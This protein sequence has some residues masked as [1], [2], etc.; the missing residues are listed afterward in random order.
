M[1]ARGF[2]A[3]GRWLFFGVRLV[4]LIALGASTLAITAA[5]LAPQASDILNANRSTSAEVDLDTLA[6]RSLVFDKNGAPIGQL[7]GEINRELVTLDQISQEAITTVLTVEDAA[8]Y[9]HDGINVRAI[10]RA[11]V[12]N[13]EAGGVDQGGSTITQQLIKNSVLDDAVGVEDKIPE[14]A[15]AMRLEG[16][17]EKDEILERYLNTVYFGAGSYGIQAAAE[18]YFGVDASQLDWVQSAM[19]ASLISSPVTGDP[20]R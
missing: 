17:L 7:N 1:V 18:T 6:L 2:S 12:R 13:V 10:A 19:L 5:T 11:L 9:R 15:L 14:A 8:F 3:L 4:V 20:T 16:Q